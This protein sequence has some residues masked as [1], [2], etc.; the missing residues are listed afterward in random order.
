VGK[1]TVIRRLAH[2]LKGHRL[3]GFYTEELREGSKRYGFRLVSFAGHEALIAHIG[4]PKAVRV[5]KY[6]VDIAALEAAAVLLAPDPAVELYL[7][8]EIGKMESLAPGLVSA[9]EQLLDSAH[10]LVAT[11]AA[12]GGG[13]IADVKA[14]PDVQLIQVTHSNRDDL[15]ETLR[16]RLADGVR[17]P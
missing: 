11:V 1:T 12:K 16:R 10:P 8:D 9:I 4:F 6:G 15:A 7:L 3:A 13:L 2:R 14:R 17:K 5:G